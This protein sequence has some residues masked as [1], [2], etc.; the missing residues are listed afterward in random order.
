MSQAA[1]LRRHLTRR[2]TSGYTL[3]EV[4]VAVVILSV[5]LLGL[6]GMQAR[7]MRNSHDAYLRSQAAIL[8]YDIADRMRANRD[9]ALAGDYDI[10]IDVAAPGGT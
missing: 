9:A 2:P 3:V 5:G 8:A 4:L 6:A 1:P 7:G 10:G